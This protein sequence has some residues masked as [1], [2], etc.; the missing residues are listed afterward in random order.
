[1]E[2]N[3]TLQNQQKSS[4]IGNTGATSSPPFVDSCMY[5]KTSGF[6]FGSM[7]SLDLNEEISLK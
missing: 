5:I 1:M 3:K 2:K 6:S 4:I 7:F